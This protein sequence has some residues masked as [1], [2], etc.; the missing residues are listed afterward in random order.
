MTG[1][2]GTAIERT[3][4]N[5]AVV[6]LSS[7]PSEVITLTIGYIEHGFGNRVL[8]R[9]GGAIRNIMRNIAH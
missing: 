5:S 9:R 1:E 4:K 7:L 8:L 6:G 2:A 3:L